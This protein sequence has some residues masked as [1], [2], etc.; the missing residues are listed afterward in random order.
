MK[1][2]GLYLLT[3]VLGMTSAYSQSVRQPDIKLKEGAVAL[4]GNV[5]KIEV[6]EEDS[7]SKYAMTFVSLTL[8]L[9][10][11]NTSEV[12]LIFLQREPDCN[13][14]IIAK[15]ADDLDVRDKKFLAFS[16]ATSSDLTSV[17]WVNLR[18]S[19]DS[20]S[21][22]SENTRILAPGET[23]NF[24]GWIRFNLPK[25]PQMYA[26][27]PTKSESLARL[28]E[29]SPVL[30]RVQCVAWPLNLEGVNNER[31]KLIFG[32]ELQTRWKDVGLLWLKD[33]YSEPILL[34]LKTATY[35]TASR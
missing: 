15:N 24:D 30:L 3:L 22:P 5:E 2:L 26:S 33:I 6:E 4:R 17:K 12:P 23:F 11:T 13:Q 32:R 28:Q 8:K 20:P 18:K 7:S 19:L 25:E 31:R 1:V 10:I 21:P 9:S 29:L 16:G 27:S 14:A 35:K 34:D